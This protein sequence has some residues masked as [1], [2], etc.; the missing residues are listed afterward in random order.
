VKGRRDLAASAAYEPGPAAAAAAR[1]F[2]RETICSWQLADRSSQ[3]VDDAVLLTS[4]LVTNAI[5]HAG[6]PLRVSCRL[7]DG[8]VEVTVQDRHPARMLRDMNGTAVGA[9]RTNGRGLLLPVALASSWGVSYTRT[10]K[11]VWFRIAATDRSVAR[12]EPGAGSTGETFGRAAP[13]PDVG[14]AEGVRPGPAAGDPLATIGRLSYDE[15]LRRTVEAA[16]DMAGADAAY[17]LV[18]DEDGELRIRAGAGLGS[19]DLLASLA[20]SATGFAQAPGDGDGPGRLPAVYNDLARLTAPATVAA[21]ENDHAARSLVTVPLLSEGRVT[22]V[23][24]AAAAE[25]DRFTNVDADRLQQVADRVALSLERARLAELERVRR[26]RISF[27]AEA[28]DLLAG[29]LDEDKTVALAAQ[30]V[31]PRLA[32]WCAVYLLGD[33]ADGARAVARPAYVWHSDE[34]LADAL[35]ALLARVPPPQVPSRAV[36]RRWSLSRPNGSELP[37]GTPDFATDIV[38]CCPLIARGR[39]LGAFVIGRP[40]GDR[41]PRESA[42]MVEDLG[43]R[44]ALAL[45]NAR[46]YSQQL[47]TS[48]A[49]Q[50]SLLPPEVPEVPGVDLA[51]AY[52]AAGEGNEV[53]GDFYDV[54]AV[55]EDRWRFAIGDVCGTGPEAAAVTGLARY[56]LRILAR[57]GRGVAEVLER[58]NRLILDEGPRARFITLVHGEIITERAGGRSS[59]GSTS[60]GAGSAGAGVVGRNGLAPGPPAFR[61]SLVCAGHPLP[62]LLRSAGKPEPAASPQPLL[63]VLEHVSFRSETIGLEP[64]DMLLCVTDGVTERRRG[65]QLLDDSGGL[66]DVFAEC[67]GLNAGA[68]AARI[69]RVVRDFA[70]QPPADDTALIVLRAR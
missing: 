13:Q 43:R 50:R 63:G 67:V 53:G 32:T 36:A 3:L 29:T 65:G 46:L 34:A 39:V 22:G 5:V 20:G 11:A 19:P 23:L 26:G 9:E 14:T 8:E 27:L 12:Q 47:Q 54:F 62:L 2:V 24:A 40:R 60:D 35:R 33:G 37:K 45:D 6:T 44:V 15:L 64:G 42:E 10:A 38:L 31:V 4:E 61:V 68:V 57:E 70:P 66:I 18:A 7:D 30:L 16:R 41:F 52:A 17:A 21:A 59:A 56:T 49:L 69:M 1:R 48:R 28:S 25:P 51:A 58:L 55:A